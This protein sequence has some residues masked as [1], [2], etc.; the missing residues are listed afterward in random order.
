METR[1]AGVDATAVMAAAEEVEEAAVEAGVVELPTADEPEAEALAEAD[2]DPL[3][4]AEADADAADEMTE[5]LCASA[6]VARMSCDGLEEG[7]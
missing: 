7:V 4:D 1:L 6:E 5:V 3:A 2:P